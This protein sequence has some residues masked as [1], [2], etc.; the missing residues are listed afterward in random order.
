MSSLGNCEV[1]NQGNP[2]PSI[3]GTCDLGGLHI[4]AKTI[5]EPDPSSLYGNGMINNGMLDWEFYGVNSRPSAGANPASQNDFYGNLYSLA[6]YFSSE[7]GP[8]DY[9]VQAP[10]VKTIPVMSDPMPAPC[11]CNGNTSEGPT[12]H[13]QQQLLMLLGLIAVAFFLAKN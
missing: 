11:N 6:S 10:V 12:S 7:G 1:D 3:G 5:D 2:L 9:T 8:M 13:S 4:N